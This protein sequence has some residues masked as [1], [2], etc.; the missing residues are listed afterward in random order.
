MIKLN[1]EKWQNKAHIQIKQYVQGG[2]SEG[3]K[4]DWKQVIIE[5]ELES[6]NWIATNG[7]FVTIGENESNFLITLTD[8][9]KLNQ[10]VNT[11][12]QYSRS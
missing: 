7:T 4:P 11:I 10:W 5:K 9:P 8:E 1:P 3:K 6:I 2:I 12:Y